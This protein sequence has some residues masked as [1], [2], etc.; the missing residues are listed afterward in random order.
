MLLGSTTFLKNAVGL[1][2]IFQKCCWAQQHFSKMLVRP[3]VFFLKD[4]GGAKEK[5]VGEPTSIFQK[6]C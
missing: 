1:N 6:C 3:T 4:A 2:N 5:N